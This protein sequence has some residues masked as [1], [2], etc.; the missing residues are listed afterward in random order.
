[1]NT[2]I[3]TLN[4]DMTNVKSYVNDSGWITASLGSNFVAYNTAGTPKYRKVGK[5]VTVHGVV[6][7]K[8]AI[9]GSSTLYTIFTLPAGY[10]PT[11]PLALRLQ[12]SG[13]Y[14]WM[15]QISLD[16]IVTFSRYSSPGEAGY[17]NTSTSTWLPFYAT[18]FVN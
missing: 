4:T 10:R 5:I 8:S 17:V 1:M 13:L 18:Y 9:T 12:G 15:F 14:T 6:S 3:D 11:I 7:P 2:S 16:G